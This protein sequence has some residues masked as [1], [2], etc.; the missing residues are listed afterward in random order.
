MTELWRWVPGRQK[1]GYHKCLLA[2]SSR[3]FKFDLYL[4]RF[5]EGCEVPP[6]RD[7]IKAGKHYRLNIVLK[8]AKNGGEF[9][10]SE[11]IYASKRIKLFRPDVCE[12]A[13][14]RVNEG[15]RYLLSLGWVRND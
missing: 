4:L 12:H 7:I 9:L 15:N 3:F 10:C 5:P 8:Q 1:S 6:H 13:V 11:P 2:R 14:T